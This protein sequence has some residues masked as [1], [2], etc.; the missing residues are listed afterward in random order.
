MYYEVGARPLQPGHSIAVFGTHHE[1]KMRPSMRHAV[2]KRWIRTAALRKDMFG[3]FWEHDTFYHCARTPNNPC[4]AQITICATAVD[5]VFVVIRCSARAV[6]YRSQPASE[7]VLK[8]RAIQ[9][10]P[11]NMIH[12]TRRSYQRTNQGST[13]D[14]TCPESHEMNEDLDLILQTISNSNFK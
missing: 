2:F 7:H 1:K 6:S 4:I 11:A 12:G 8:S 9:T 3:S 14:C 10:H 5:P 13:T